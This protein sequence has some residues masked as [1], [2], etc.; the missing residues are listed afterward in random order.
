M[1]IRVK[2]CFGILI[3]YYLN[4]EH[5]SESVNLA[6]AGKRFKIPLKPVQ[7]ISAYTGCVFNHLLPN[8]YFHRFHCC[9]SADRMSG[10]CVGDEIL[11]LDFLPD[12]VAKGYSSKGKIGASKPFGYNHDVGFDSPVFDSEHLTGPAKSCHNLISYKQDIVPR[13]YT[14]DK[15]P[16]LWRGGNHTPYTKLRFGNKCRYA[17]CTFL[18]N[19]F[20]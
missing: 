1:E 20:C 2:R 11:A 8:V 6:N 4:A 15:R 10:I 7:S 12:V 14:P 16:V 19:D 13:A 18:L 17:F 9:C 3:G 5:Q